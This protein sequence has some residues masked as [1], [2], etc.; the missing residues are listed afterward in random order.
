MKKQSEFIEMLHTSELVNPE[1]I[2]FLCKTPAL[3][4]LEVDKLGGRIFLDVTMNDIN[5]R[6]HTSFN[7][8]EHL[9]EFE[10]RCIEWLN[11]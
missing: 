9:L 3:K 4:Q 1:L 8:Q 11:Y 5:I 6:V 2:L 7:K 10:R